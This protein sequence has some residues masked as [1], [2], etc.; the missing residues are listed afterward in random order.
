M[1]IPVLDKNKKPL[2]PTS[3]VS[4]LHEW[5]YNA[6]VENVGSGVVKRGKAKSRSPNQK[7]ADHALTSVRYCHFCQRR[8]LFVHEKIGRDGGKSHAHSVCQECGYS[9][10]LSGDVNHRLKIIKTRMRWGK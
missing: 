3:P 5:C 4:E 1:Q 7:L 8:T 6:K 2:M 9:A 10:S